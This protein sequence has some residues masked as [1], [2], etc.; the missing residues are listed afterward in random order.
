MEQINLKTKYAEVIVDIQNSNVDKIFDYILKADIEVG[1]RVIVPFGNR[2]I[3]GY[4]VKIKDE[5]LLEK[6]KLKEIIEPVDDFA[7]INKERIELLWFMKEKYNLK[8]IDVLRLFLPAELR[9]GKVKA[10]THKMLSLS[11]EIDL[12]SYKKTLR[13]NATNLFGILNYLEQNQTEFKTTLCNQFSAGSVNRLI[14]DNVLIIENIKKYRKPFSE[15]VANKNLVWTN[16]QKRA[17]EEITTFQNQTYLLHG[18]TGS[19]KTEVYMGVISQVLA[20]G[21]T[22]IMLVP[23]ISLT[24]QV[25]S[26]L[27][28]KFSSNVAIL[29]SGLSQ[30]E[31]FDE[32]M[33]IL[34]KEASVV[35]GARSAIFAPVEDVGI[36]I[37]DEEHDGSYY[38][39][40]NPRFNTHVVAEFRKN[41]NN[42]P[43]ILGSATPSV[44]SYYKTTT[45]EYK[46]LNMPTRINKKQMP[47]I[48]IVDMLTQIK[49]GNSG[50][51]SSYMTSEL[52]Q[53]VKNKKQAMLFL[54]RRGFSS[55]MMCRA[56]GYVAKCSDCDVS[57][58]YHKHEST[59]QCHYCNKKYKALTKCPECGSD[60]IRQ[61]AI[62]TERVVAEV[63]EMFPDVKVLRMDND[64]TKN[65]NGHAQILKEFS[66]TKPSILVGT[67]MIAKGHD[68][69]DVTFVGIVDGDQSLYHSDYKSA[70]RTF[71]LITQMSGRAGRDEDE[72]KAI[73]QT[74]SPK[75]YVY[76]FASNYDY[77]GFFNKEINLRQ[78]THFPPFS[79]I[80]RLLFSSE[81]DS[82]VKQ[83]IKDC[84]LEIVN[85]ESQHKKDFYYLD[86]M[87]SPVG[88]IQRKFRY[89]ILI[90]ID[91]KNQDE[92]I[93]RI[94][95]ICDKQKN[96]KVSVFVEINPQSL[97]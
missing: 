14:E 7:V 96:A 49:L 75:H 11:S 37:I 50:L 19:G 81:N 87:K 68:F 17:V 76:R 3:E 94:Y 95:E 38:S 30:G 83:A 54:N 65:K 4:I 57:L 73:L 15:T 40:N 90:R 41:F 16:E 89:Q 13:K 34:N 48:Q 66:E 80:I 86:A 91:V 45:N 67:Q 97:S 84:Y 92:L 42:C 24:P 46:L 56:C 28:A 35:V 60:S 52:E 33:R 8:L 79:T 44:E 85:L 39:E 70:E 69:K 6:D 43:L 61:G 72:G 59:L 55:F 78:V 62:G 21:K 58:V 22:A 32:W 29:H 18:V 23:E 93:K 12:D 25:L 20:V 2:K 71:A 36:I 53:V 51:F 1:T 77:Q 26:S 31:R 74:Y 63:K 88:R 5:T 27:R 10:L 47:K 64:T 9:S 82:L